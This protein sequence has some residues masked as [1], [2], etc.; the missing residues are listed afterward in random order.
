MGTIDSALAGFE[1][2]RTSDID[3]ARH[4]VERL[5]SPHGVTP[6]RR[7]ARFDVCYRSVNLVDTT[8]IH[9]RYGA[10]VRIDPGALESFYLVGVPLAGTS[11]VTC[12]D[13]QIVSHPGLASVQS[14]TRPVATEWDDDCCKLSVKVQRAALER[15]L[16]ELLGYPVK[17]PVV[18]EAGLDLT[19]GSGASWRRLVAFLLEELTP[20]SIYLSSTAARRSL[21][22]TLISSLLYAQRHTYS[23]ALLAE[24]QPAAPAHVRRAEEIIAADPSCACTLD[25]LAARA[26]TSVRSLQAGFRRHRGMTPVEFMRMQ[27]LAHAREALLAA[28][29]ETTVTDVA[30]AAG[31]AHLGRFAGDYKARYGEPPST[32]LRRAG[33]R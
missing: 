19:Q 5:L 11:R 17:Q 22:R 9:A 20:E 29:P 16:A 10:A 26:G 18:F 31:Y 23:D 3:E 32:T 13:R 14:C 12:G 24:A 28:T 15:C 4:E 8:I 1:R 33:G 27:R 2:F 21:D 25:E 7:A 6:R 30:L